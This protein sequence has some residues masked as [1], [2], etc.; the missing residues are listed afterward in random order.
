MSGPVT[1]LTLPSQIAAYDES[2][3]NQASE[4]FDVPV[5]IDPTIE[6]R[7]EYGFGYDYSR[8]IRLREWHE[9]VF[10]HEVLHALVDPVV[11]FVKREDD[12]TPRRTI[13]LAG[14]NH[15]IIRRV[16]VGLTMAGW[17]WTGDRP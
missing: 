10:L 5:V 1:R 16:E 15:D 4:T 7:G 6:H 11:P 14:L 9:Q 17:C 8:V 12:L 13:G 2:R 3:V